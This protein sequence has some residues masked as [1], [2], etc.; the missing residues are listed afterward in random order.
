MSHYHS[1]F[2]SNGRDFLAWKQHKEYL[3]VRYRR[4]IVKFSN[5]SVEAERNNARAYFRQSYHADAYHDEG[6]KMIE[7]KKDRDSWKIFRE[8]WFAKRPAAWPL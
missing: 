4:I 3:Y 6:Y 8:E 2:E 7:L 1:D 5:L